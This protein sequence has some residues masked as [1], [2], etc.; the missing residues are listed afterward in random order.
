MASITRNITI[1]WEMSPDDKNIT[2]IKPKHREALEESATKHIFEMLNE[3][4]TSGKL[5]DNIFIN[6]ND[7]DSNGNLGI[8]Y[9]GWF[10]VTTETLE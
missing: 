4:Y 9:S 1:Q 6:G 10:N 7:V 5:S 8:A 3:G 2:E